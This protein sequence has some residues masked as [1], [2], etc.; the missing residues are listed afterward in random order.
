MNKLFITVSKGIAGY[1]A[2][3]A[4]KDGPIQTGIGRY[5]ER[6]KACREARHWAQIEHLP[7]VGVSFPLLTEQSQRKNMTTIKKSI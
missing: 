5:K 7:L 6:E 3:L 1:F 2:L 4:D